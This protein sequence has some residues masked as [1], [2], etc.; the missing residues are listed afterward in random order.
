MGVYVFFFIKE[1]KGRTLES[2]DILFGAVDE[3][4]RVQD[5]EQAMETEKQAVGIE[6][7]EFVE[8]HTVTGKQ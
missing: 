6:H 5:L 1:T 4:T 8:T 7:H 2:M 3:E